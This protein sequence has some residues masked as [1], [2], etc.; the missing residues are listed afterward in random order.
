MSDPQPASNRIPWLIALALFVVGAWLR[1]DAA[2]P[3]TAGGT[4]EYLYGGYVRFLDAN[5]LT[6]YPDLIEHYLNDPRKSDDA[7]AP[8]TR[9]FY[10]ASGTLVKVWTGLEA[11]RCLN[12]VSAACS[13]L[14]LPLAFGFAVRAGG[15]R[16]GL[17]T[18]A[19]LVFAPTQLFMARHA[20][21]DVTVSLWTAAALWALWECLQKPDEPRR[22]I[23]LGLS[24]AILIITKENSFFPMLA[25]AAIV[26]ANRWF[27][28]GTATPRLFAAAGAGI[29]VGVAILSIASGGLDR[30][31]A[32]LKLFS[33]NATRLPYAILTGD[34]P[35]HRYLYEQALVSPLIIILTFILLPRLTGKSSPQ[36][37][38]L[39]FFA[40]SYA[41]MASVRYGMSLRFANLW[42][43]PLRFLAASCLVS[44]FANVRWRPAFV[45]AAVTLGIGFYD[46][47]QYDIIFVEHHVYDPITPALLESVDML[48]FPKGK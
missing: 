4:D 48:K 20:L 5:S 27:K 40:V 9:I 43:F 46:L 33:T 18:L 13:I 10:I 25:L 34:G 21:I 39:I 16:I 24:V 45:L 11:K 47:R 26:L 29:L 14:L 15:M 38:L 19:L 17:V 22:L 7:V 28:W 35:W 44:L 23:A 42:D 1:I 37:Y 41:A 12:I 6:A 8:P 31:V 36:V 2:A 32:V 30:A 3:Y